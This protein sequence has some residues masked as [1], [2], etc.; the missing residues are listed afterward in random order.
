[1]T[2]TS[3]PQTAIE[4]KDMRELVECTSEGTFVNIVDKKTADAVADKF[5]STM[6][7]YPTKKQI[8]IRE[9]FSNLWL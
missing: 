7:V 9:Y 8:L 4:S 3:E 2:L 6:D 1:M 5:F